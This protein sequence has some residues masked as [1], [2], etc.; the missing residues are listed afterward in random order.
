MRSEKGFSLIEIL[1]VVAILGVLSAIAVPKYLDY[2]ASAKRNATIT[3]FNTAAKVIKGSFGALRGGKKTLGEYIAEANKAGGHNPYFPEEPAFREGAAEK[4]G[5]VG[6]ELI[7]S[8]GGGPG[9]NKLVIT[10]RYLKT[11]PATGETGPFTDTNE[12][13]F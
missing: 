12:I 13:K 1:L 8:E 4:E 10:A 3:N 9:S 2:V 6:I 7:L 11:D 5:E